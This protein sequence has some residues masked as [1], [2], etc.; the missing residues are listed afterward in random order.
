MQGQE[1]CIILKINNTS[2][3]CMSHDFGLRGSVSTVTS[4][5]RATI[6]YAL[7]C[8]LPLGVNVDTYIVEKQSYN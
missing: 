6:L 8:T 5:K 7:L 4:S 1:G 2:K 3:P